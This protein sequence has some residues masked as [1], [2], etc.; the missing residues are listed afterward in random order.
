MDETQKELERIDRELA[1]LEKEAQEHAVPHPPVEEVSA[2]EAAAAEEVTESEAAP[3]DLTELSARRAEVAAQRDNK[4]IM[5]L[6]I[7]ASVLC[8]GIISVLIYWLEAFLD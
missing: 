5:S 3:A 7:L 8:L 6:M 2:P 1:A 4:T